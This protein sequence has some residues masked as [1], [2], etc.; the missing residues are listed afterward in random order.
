MSLTQVSFN[1]GTS[2]DASAYPKMR[3]RVRAQS[4]GQ[5]TILSTSNTYLIEG[6]ISFAPS[7]ITAEANGVHV[8]EWTTSQFNA[9]GSANSP[10]QLAFASTIMAFGAGSTATTSYS[11]TLPMNNGAKVIVRDSMSRNLPLFVDFGNVAPGGTDTVKLKIVATE[12]ALSGTPPQ[13]R[14]ARL[15]SVTT[16]TGNFKVIWKGSFGTPPPPANL[17]SPLEY[18]IDV[19]CLP[20]TSDPISDVLTVTYEDGM[21]TDVMLTANPATYP[22]RTI[23]N[24]VTPNGGE[25]FAPCQHIPVSWSG[26]VPGFKA[27]VEFTLDNGRTWKLI[28]STLDSMLVWRTP[29]ALSDSARIRVYQAFQS[30]NPV[31]LDGERSQALNAAYSADGKYLAVGYSNGAVVEWDITTN[32]K[33]NTYR[34]E[35]MTG[36]RIS[37][38]AFIGRTR[39]I[40]AAF[41]RMVGGGGN[42]VLFE[43]GN[44]SSVATEVI[45]SDVSVS[46]IGTDVNGTV[47]YAV[48]YRSGRI[49][50]YDATTLAVR[51][52]INLTAPASTSIP[53]KC[54]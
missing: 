19:V 43:A 45:P 35:P 9:F 28:D 41:T 11:A 39:N 3:A 30:S 46:D 51:S 34:A 14:R 5:P 52:A 53:A 33:T 7:K 49:L 8:V 44:A 36:L 54:Y 10:R 20:T 13:E 31:W 6:N 37:A 42:V 15:E 26:M 23:L 24:L 2:L 32:T 25:S 1:T 22:R 4:G 40:A 47:L 17:I 18:R 29:Q 12:V 38:V 48:P 16:K 27:Y 21:R 50:R